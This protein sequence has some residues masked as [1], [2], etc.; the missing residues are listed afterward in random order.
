MTCKVIHPSQLL[1]MGFDHFCVSFLADMRIDYR[2]R[3]FQTLL[4][5]CLVGVEVFRWAEL[6]TCRK[7]KHVDAPPM[8]SSNQSSQRLAEQIEALTQSNMM[9]HRASHL[10]KALQL[11]DQELEIIITKVMSHI[12]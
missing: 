8:R 11:F 10:S 3:L 2:L 9:A 5:G 7:S 4:Q 1:P 6:E 12:C